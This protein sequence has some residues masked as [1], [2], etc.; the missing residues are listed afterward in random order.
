MS[1]PRWVRE[2]GVFVVHILEVINPAASG[3]LLFEIKINRLLQSLWRN[4]CQ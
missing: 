3:F 2:K 4:L 1:R